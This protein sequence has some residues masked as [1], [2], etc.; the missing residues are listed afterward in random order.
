MVGIGT[1]CWDR[2]R[3]YPQADLM[4]EKAIVCNM[5]HPLPGTPLPLATTITAVTVYAERAQV[6]RRGRL[7]LTPGQVWVE[8]SALPTTLDPESVQAH[9]L[10][11]AI[12]VPQGLQVTTAVP[13][14]SPATIQVHELEAQLRAAKDHLSTLT[15]QRDWLDELA[16]RSART[17]ALGLSQQQIALSEVE[18]MLQ[19][20]GQ[21]HAQLSQ[22]I[23]QQERTK[24]DLDHQLQAARQRRYDHG[25]TDDA[26]RYRV[27]IPLGVHQ[28]G[29]LELEITYSVAGVSWQPCYDIWLVESSGQLQLDCQAQVQQTT[30]EDWEEVA[31]TLST[32]QPTLSPTPPQPEI[33]YVSPSKKVAGPLPRS[34]DDAPGGSQRSRSP[35]LE[36][37]YR[38]LGALPGS[39]LPANEAL[40]QGESDQGKAFAAAVMPFE[41]PQPTTVVSRDRPCVVSMTQYNIPSDISYVSLP[42]HS[43]APYLQVSA[44]HSA[45][46]LPLLPGPAHLFRGAGYIGQRSLD[47]IAPGQSFQLMLGLDPRLQVQRQRVERQV[48]SGER[49]RIRLAYRLTL[50]NPLSQSVQVRVVEQIPV[51][52]SQEIQVALDHADPATDADPATETGFCRW[53][54]TLP[55][56]SDHHIYYRYTVEHPCDVPVQ[57]LA[58]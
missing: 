54:L 58:V 6:T 9:S 42:Q 20:L 23:A 56:Q 45:D 25:D 40:A 2:R 36:D 4:P 29:E 49:C 17:F 24:H 37:T 5:G 41:V 55:P 51:S 28:A 38:M 22:A 46:G 48:E 57:G 44:I 19:F 12:A 7:S 47:Y 53:S 26:P 35:I 32:A 11:A 31:L 39:E 16:Q 15:L 14:P 21:Q 1:W 10:D 13:P 8:I 3:P 18:S 33:W 43:N 30:G 27:L 52:R 50:H 34:D